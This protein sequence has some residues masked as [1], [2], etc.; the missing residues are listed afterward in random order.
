[1]ALGEDIPEEPEDKTVPKYKQIDKVRLFLNLGVFQASSFDIFSSVPALMLWTGGRS[2]K[3]RSL[4][5]N[6]RTNRRQQ[7]DPS[8]RPQ[9]A[10]IYLIEA[11]RERKRRIQTIQW[12]TRPCGKLSTRMRSG[13]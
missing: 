5:G 1:M 11:P 2:C 13:R 3:P 10:R 7:L 12:V 6:K 9:V 8:V 4:L